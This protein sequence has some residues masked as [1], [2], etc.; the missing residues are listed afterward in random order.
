M[1]KI[2]T[3]SSILVLAFSF[4]CGQQ[5]IYKLVPPESDHAQVIHMLGDF[6]VF[7]MTKA[8]FPSPSQGKSLSFEDYKIETPDFIAENDRQKGKFTIQLK[9]FDNFL[10]YCKDFN[11][12]EVVDGG[13]KPLGYIHIWT[14]AG[15]VRFG[16]S[17]LSDMKY[18]RKCVIGYKI[19]GGKLMPALF[20]GNL[21]KEP[22]PF[23]TANKI[24]IF[25]TDAAQ[26]M[27]ADIKRAFA[28]EKIEIEPK[29]SKITFTNSFPFPEK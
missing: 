12:L 16:M 6:K 1:R 19:D 18:F 4:L 14:T 11:I 26:Y 20:E 5:K 3:F 9:D 17:S 15:G 24:E 22:I 7:W 29:L 25:V 8:E 2:C 13:Y 23:D 21:R 27:S 28:I 10:E